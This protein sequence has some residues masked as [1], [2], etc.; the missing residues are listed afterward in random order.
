MKTQNISLKHTRNFICKKIFSI[1]PHNQTDLND[2]LKYPTL[3]FEE[4]DSFLDNHFE[5]QNF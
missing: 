5:R 2:N 1:S 3:N 4:E